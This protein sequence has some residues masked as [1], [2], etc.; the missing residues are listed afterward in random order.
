[1]VTEEI[2]KFAN[3]LADISIPIAQKYFRLPNGE[4]AK[5]DDSPVTKA[6]REIEEII[7]AEIEKKF[8]EHGIIGE[9]Y[10]NKNV[11][12]DYVWVL[13]P[14][15][16]TSSFI[17]GRP[18]FGTLIALTYRKKPILGIM[19]QPISGERWIGI[20]GQGSWFNGK[21][22]QTRNCTEISDAVM[23]ASSPFFFK[24]ED[25]EILKRVTAQTKY[26]RLGGIIYGGD[27]YSYSSLA[28][29]F[30][31][32]IIEPE[33]KVYDYAALI[34]I[35]E[36]AGGVVTDWNGNDLELKSNVRL[37]ACANKELH[38]KVLKILK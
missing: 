21:K 4:I 32:L 12:A 35:I 37:I 6:D 13:D 29:G 33:L 11:D 5:E 38:Q 3:F 10:G 14:I 23:C 20:E 24:N 31:D 30:V 7:R 25:A 28:S 26:Q 8:P 22:I 9:E 19:N 34:P 36:M 18:I 2:T 16:G 17:I 27:C 15:D 1:M